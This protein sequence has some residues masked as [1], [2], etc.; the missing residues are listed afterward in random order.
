MMKYSVLKYSETQKKETISFDLTVDFHM[1]SFDT[2]S[3][4]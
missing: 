2:I 4:L 3:F 1:R